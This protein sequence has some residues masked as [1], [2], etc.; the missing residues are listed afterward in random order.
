MSS[1]SKADAEQSETAAQDRQ[2]Q[3]DA[4]FNC[5]TTSYNLQVLKRA[6]SLSGLSVSQFVMNAS[7]TA[8][9]D[10]IQNRHHTVLSERDWKILTDSGGDSAPP[11][12][13]LKE[14][15]PQHRARKT[16]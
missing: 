12:E 11:T 10:L 15:A 16:K 6:A 13:A 9:H 3:R 14:L 5:R 7:L 1:A 8:A 4:R 2:D